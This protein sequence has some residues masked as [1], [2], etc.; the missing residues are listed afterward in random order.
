MT[1]IVEDL[2]NALGE[3]AVLSGKDIA[4]RQLH[5]WSG[6]PSE[7]PLAIVLPRSTA[8][9]SKV[10]SLCHAYA[11]PIVVQGGLTGLVGG[12]NP[13]AGEIVLSLERMAA[14][15]EVDVESSTMT[16]QAGAI[17]QMVQ[18]AADEQGMLFP[19]DLGARGSCTIGGN[20]ATNAGGN[21][22]I[23]HGMARKHV[24]ALEAVLA[25]GSIVGTL[26]K[27]IK[28]NTGYDLTDLFIGSEGTLAVITRATFALSAKPRSVA[29]AW[30]GLP[31]FKSVVTLLRRAQEH[32]PGCVSAFEVMWPTYV[33]YML[34]H[35]GS[36]RSPLSSDHAFYV[37]FET[38]G[39]NDV[40]HGEVFE[41]F[42]EEM[43]T[44]GVLQDAAVARSHD[45]ASAFWSIRDA[46][47]ELSTLM[48]N[49]VA[50]DIS[51]PIA[52]IK[53]AVEKIASILD[54]RW[55]GN[56]ALFYGH[57]GDGNLHL[58]AE[59]PE[60]SRS[61]R[62]EVESVI[63]AVTGELA[64]SISA[65]HGIGIKKRPYLRHSRSEA[66]VA[67]MAVIKAALDPIEI[68]GRGRVFAS[69]V[70]RFNKHKSN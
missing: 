20:L 38:V 12:A 14:I 18:E 35:I 58:I 48:P 19:L 60:G 47:G 56:I 30:C 39:G 52:K 25:D 68:L 9:V 34:D 64:G 8:E 32:M 1:A 70:N 2:R 55:P 63:Y 53:E 40:E 21:R 37:L 17:L 67:T 13:E 43:L 26:S 65:E 45:D 24:L 11:Q 6:C 62:H 15:E 50:F 23:K 22:V 29:T 5:D 4:G 51:F 66:E 28:N 61:A 49:L 44:V 31:D 16:V 46:A 42:M 59:I 10:L 27:T 33:K 7:T 57:L 3:G 54:V 69:N 36:L 41:R